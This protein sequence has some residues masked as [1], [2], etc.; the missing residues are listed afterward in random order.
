MFEL[1][2]Y[3]NYSKQ[4]KNILNK[5]GKLIKINLGNR[6]PYIVLKPFKNFNQDFKIT[7]LYIYST[8]TPGS[9]SFSGKFFQSREE[10]S[11]VR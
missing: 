3:I 5:E 1:Y 2:E 10:G 11:N 6:K 4:N 8:T 7:S 9:E